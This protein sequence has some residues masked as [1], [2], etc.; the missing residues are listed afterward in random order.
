MVIPR[1]T[2]H[3]HLQEK[4]LPPTN[5]KA[6]LSHTT[7]HT[8]GACIYGLRM[9]RRDFGTAPTSDTMKSGRSQPKAAACV[10]NLQL[11]LVFG[12]GLPKFPSRRITFL[13]APAPPS[14]TVV[15]VVSRQ[16]PKVAEYSGPV[17]FLKQAMRGA[18]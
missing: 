11:L 2:Y 6:L 10:T 15:A 1:Y 9:W 16:L 3:L 4:G 7:W 12:P 5:H 8:V 18:C 13:P 17:L 14:V